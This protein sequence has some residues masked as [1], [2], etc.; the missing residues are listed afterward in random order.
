MLMFWPAKTDASQRPAMHWVISA[1]C[2]KHRAVLKVPLHL[3][4]PL[5]GWASLSQ[6]GISTSQEPLH[7]A[8]PAP[9]VMQKAELSSTPFCYASYRSS[10]ISLFF[11]L[12]M[13]M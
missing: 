10:V 11:F 3:T 6:E 13:P 7:Q 5:L 1:L 2:Q 4:S 8:P 12:S 9:S